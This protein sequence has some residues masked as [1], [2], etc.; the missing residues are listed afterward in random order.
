MNE[1]LGI[2]Y[3]DQKVIKV[4]REQTWAGRIKLVGE[5]KVEFSSDPLRG[6]GMKLTGNWEW[7][8]GDTIYLSSC[9]ST[10]K[11]SNDNLKNMFF[12][13]L[14]LMSSLAKR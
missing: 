3:W 11:K 12:Q 2:K 1:M 5:V 4:F 13:Y 6:K 7:Y 14:I 10:G 9:V 8:Q